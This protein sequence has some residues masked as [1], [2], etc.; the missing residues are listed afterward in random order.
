MSLAEVLWAIAIGFA[1]VMP[2]VAIIEIRSWRRDNRQAKEEFVRRSKPRKS[3]QFQA[4]LGD[5]P[6]QSKARIIGPK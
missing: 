2:T 1:I 5:H 3:S 4:N 6:R